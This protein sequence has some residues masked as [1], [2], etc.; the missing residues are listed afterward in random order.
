MKKELIR[1]LKK[2]LDDIKDN[3]NSLNELNGKIKD[4]EGK[5]AY[6]TKILE[7]PIAAPTPIILVLLNFSVKFA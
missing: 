4:E 2:K 5:L 1:V 7:K 3:I 6:A